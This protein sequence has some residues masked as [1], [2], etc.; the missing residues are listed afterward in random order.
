MTEKAQSNRGNRNRI[1]NVF[2]KA[3]A[4]ESIT[5]GFL[6]GSITQGCAATSYDKCY[7]FKVFEWFKNSFPL[8]D[9]KYINAGI[10]ATDSQ[11][12]C[13]RAQDDLLSKKPSPTEETEEGSLMYLRMRW[14]VRVSP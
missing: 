6:G 1:I 12:G 14:Q 3:M 9:V 13:A 8:S 4:G 5:V 11:F 7:A 2:K 10:G